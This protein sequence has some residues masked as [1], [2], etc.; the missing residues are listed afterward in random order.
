MVRLAKLVFIAPDFHGPN[1]AHN[2]PGYRE[3]D[4][5]GLS[6]LGGREE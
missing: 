6:L 4:R 2:P 3:V 5:L 1:L